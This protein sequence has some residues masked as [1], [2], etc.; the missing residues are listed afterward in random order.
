MA[1]STFVVL[2]TG[3]SGFLGK[4][5]VEEL[6]RQKLLLSLE[7]VILLIRSKGDK[8]AYERFEDQITSSPRFRGLPDGWAY[9]HIATTATHSIHAAG[10]VKFDEKSNSTDRPKARRSLSINDICLLVQT[11]FSEKEPDIR[12]V[13]HGRLF[14]ACEAL[15]HGAPLSLHSVAWRML[16]RPELG[17]KSWKALRIVKAPNAALNR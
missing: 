15:Y 12:F 10:C 2:V 11:Y 9:Q 6:F 17:K 4:A 16:G 5:V 3:A 14:K 1:S 7:S 13:G 8:T